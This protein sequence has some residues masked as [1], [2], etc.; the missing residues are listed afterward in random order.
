[1]SADIRHRGTVDFADLVDLCTVHAVACR[2]ERVSLR[3]SNLADNNH[4]D[5]VAVDKR[6]LL[7]ALATML[8]LSSAALAAA[9]AEWE[10]AIAADS[11][12]EYG[13][14]IISN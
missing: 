14:L 6:R 9:S 7:V 5:M 10:A 11:L 13:H 8:S 12:T 1:M 3:G 2:G 4:L